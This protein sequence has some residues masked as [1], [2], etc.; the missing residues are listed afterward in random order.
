MPSRVIVLTVSAI[1]YEGESVGREIALDVGLAGEF[2]TSNL[3]LA[4]GQ[5]RELAREVAQ[6]WTDGDDFAA[7][8]QIQVTERD[9]VYS[10]TGSSNVDWNL[11]L[12][13]PGLLESVQRV[14]VFE[15]GGQK[16]GTAGVFLVT[17][18]ARVVAA[19]RFVQEPDTGWLTVLDENGKRIA[20]PETLCVELFRVA[21]GREHFTITEGPHRGKRASVRLNS[22]GSSVLS[23]NDPRGRPVKAI[24]SVSRKTLTI[25]TASY[26]TV[27]Y[28]LKPWALG[29]YDIEIPDAPHKGG[30]RYP[31]ASRSRTWFRVGHSGDRFIHTGAA[32]AGCITVVDRAKWDQ[33]CSALIKGR[34]GDRVSV[35]TIEVKA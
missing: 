19:T 28:P 17:L 33:I 21:E 29:I 16:E 31:E 4:P 27:D 35:G 10:E 3:R 22:D 18:R 15:A 32:S 5:T 1:Q 30:L 23:E 8:G 11:D 12:R 14:E 2:L 34:K 26:Q 20:L 24:Y 13:R 25:G 7:V 6:L 9:A